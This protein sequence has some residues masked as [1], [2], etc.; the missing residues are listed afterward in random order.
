MRIAIVGSGAVGACFGAA[1]TKAGAEV[2]FMARGMQLDAMRRN[3]LQIVGG[4]G[5]ILLNPVRVTDDPAEIG[6][7]DIVLLCTKLWDL[8]TSAAQIGPLLGPDTGVIPV[9]NG[10][11]AAD[12]LAAVVG[13]AAA[14]VGTVL[15]GGS[16]ERP[17]VIRQIGTHMSVTFGERDGRRSPRAHRFL[18]A[19]QMARIDASIAEDIA[20]PL[21]IKFIGLIAMSGATALSRQPIGALRDD[22]DGW[23][24][25]V[26][27]MRE[28]EA[29]GRAEGVAL[30]HDA[31][32]GRMTLAHSIP[33]ESRAS[34]AVDLEQGRQLELPWLA[35]KVVDL[36]RKHGIPTPVNHTVLAAL[37]PY[38][39]GRQAT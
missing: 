12:R 24:F 27:L 16:I 1:L 7:V 17:G 20:V 22:P 2:A 10:V 26:A 30:P 14:M 39:A 29:V 21:W 23:A 31:V 34:M 38:V 9:Q 36:G 6:P 25:F 19:C 8:E 11:D 15:I 28:A 32:E 18:E 37:K 5:D 33:P 35:G 4:R 13:P 3:G